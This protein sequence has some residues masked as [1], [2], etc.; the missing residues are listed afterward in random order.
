MEIKKEMKVKKVFWLEDQFKD[1]GAYKSTL[2]RA[3]YVV[4]TVRSVSEAVKKLRKNN[5]IAVIFDIKV[6]PGDD[7]RW[8]ELDE[9]KLE[10]NPDSDSYLGLELLRS[11]LNPAIANVKLD[12]PIKIDS[13]KIIVLS[14]VF[15]RTEE[16]SSLGIPGYQVL[17]K[18]SSDPKHLVQMIQNMETRDEGK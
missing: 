17:Y 8:I 4:D 5:Y 12:P 15:D 18:A 1:F 16:I 13:K 6:L 2:F 11:L 9:K 10:E 3:G 7:P 14:V